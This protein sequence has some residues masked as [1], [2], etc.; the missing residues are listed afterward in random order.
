MCVDSVALLRCSPAEL[1][2]AGG[3][4]R[5]DSKVR[6]PS[7]C[8]SPQG[9]EPTFVC[10]TDPHVLGCRQPAFLTRRFR[11]AQ[12]CLDHKR[13]ILVKLGR[14]PPDDS[15]EAPKRGRPDFARIVT[16]EHSWF[17]CCRSGCG[18]GGVDALGFRGSVVRR[19]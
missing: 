8:V 2:V 12:C 5:P 14:Q 1:P 18:T 16:Q 11:V 10:T 15:K 3:A 4:S 17:P 6:G 19:V 7:R 9:S 13:S